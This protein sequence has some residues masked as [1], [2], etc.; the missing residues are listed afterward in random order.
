MKKVSVT[1][2][3]YCCANIT[4]K[5]LRGNR[6]CHLHKMD[7]KFHQQSLIVQFICES[8]WLFLFGDGDPMPRRHRSMVIHLGLSFIRFRLIYTHRNALISMFAWH[9]NTSGSTIAKRTTE[10]G[11]QIDSDTFA[12]E[13]HEGKTS[14][15][16]LTN[17][18]HHNYCFITHSSW[19]YQS[20]RL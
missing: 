1:I 14:W 15:I 11:N 4:N 5:H 20:A 12:V 13:H 19:V 9:D 16:W 17:S 8:V 3:C 7:D 10:D 18:K 2:W 6:L